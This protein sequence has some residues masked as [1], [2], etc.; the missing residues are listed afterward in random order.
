MVSAPVTSP[1]NIICLSRA[2]GPGITGVIRDSVTLEPI[3]AKV[4]V[5]EATNSDINPR[6]SRPDTGRYRRLMAGGTYSLRFQQT[7]YRSRTVTNVVVHTTGGP[8]VVDKLLP[9]INPRPPMPVLVYPPVDTTIYDVLPHFV[10]H[11]SQ[12]A[13]KYAFELY[14]DSDVDRPHL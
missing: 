11:S 12:Y 2:L 10:W 3:E 13:T 6:L 7:G 9:P 8:T 14:S 1:G 5:T 4:V